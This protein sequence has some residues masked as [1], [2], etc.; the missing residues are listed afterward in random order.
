MANLNINQL[1]QLAREAGFP[2][3]E[4]P[5]MAAIGMAESGG[6][7]QA[8]NP[9]RSTGDNSYGAFQI[10]M[11][12]SLGE[13]R[14]RQF[15]LSRNE[16]LFD[17]RVNAKAAKAIRDSQGLGAWSVHRSGAYKQYLP[18]AQAALK[19]GDAQPIP[20]APS[21]TSAAASAT[22]AAP[23]LTELFLRTQPDETSKR[24]AS[25]EMTGQLLGAA[26]LAGVGM[27]VPQPSAATPIAETR[28]QQFP[29]SRPEV[30]DTL[31]STTFGDQGTS[32]AD[33]LKSMK[34]GAN[35][36]IMVTSASDRSGEPGS[37]FV[38]EGG[39]RGA[40]FY[41]PYAAKV[42]KVVGDQNWETNLEKGPGKRG[43]GNYVDL[44]VDLPDGQKA[45][46]RLAHFDSVNPEL[47]PGAVLPAGAFI[48][49][50][51]RTGSTTGAHVSADWYEP[52]GSHTPNTKARDY[53]LQYLRRSI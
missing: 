12:D 10:N 40:P 11:I 32:P 53:F 52:N 50:Q 41:F 44:T 4:V 22:S 33:A 29:G 16:D 13:E 47:Q 35:K 51:G 15:G 17:P 26:L 1:V 18:A 46:V 43:Y 23:D 6:R 48:G 20:S 39:R 31:I 8:H 7:A 19:G 38:V 24:M 36:G 5:I 9:N 42:H 37:D 28:P 30:I 25:P 3:N 27:Q 34:T 2:E 14:R 49:A 21:A 45:D